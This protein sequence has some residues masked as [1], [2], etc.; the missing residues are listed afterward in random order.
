MSYIPPTLP[1]S[2]SRLSIQPDGSIVVD[3]AEASAVG[4]EHASRSVSFS[5]EASAE[6]RTAPRPAIVRTVD[7]NDP[8]SS[9]TWSG[10]VR[11]GEHARGAGRRAPVVEARDGGLRLWRT[12]TH[13]TATGEWMALV[14]EEGDA[15]WR[16]ESRFDERDVAFRGEAG[17]LSSPQLYRSLV[18]VFGNPVLPQKEEKAAP[19]PNFVIEHVAK[20]RGTLVSSGELRV[21]EREWRADHDGRHAYTIKANGSLS[22]LA[23]SPAPPAPWSAPAAPA[24]P[25]VAVL[26][27]A[28][29]LGGDL[30]I[31]A[32]GS[33]G[34]SAVDDASLEA[35]VAI[36]LAAEQLIVRRAARSLVWPRTRP[37]PPSHALVSRESFIARATTPH[38]SHD[39][40]RAVVPLQV[41][42]E[43]VDYEYDGGWADGVRPEGAVAGGLFDFFN[44]F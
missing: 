44:I 27:R 17:D 19:P 32:R 33:G 26:R 12:K 22:T 6:P 9:A 40:S 2:R 1:T 41:R 18:R 28:G 23:L 29:L 34:G 7:Y 35:V 11:C 21:H 4:T 16:M 38:A 10:L 36:L 42:H 24:P 13:R 14:N 31:E 20:V 39:I 30:T 37:D 25:P 3:G 43:L 5:A 15:R 8:A